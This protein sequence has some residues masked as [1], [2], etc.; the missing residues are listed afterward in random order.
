MVL[1]NMFSSFGWTVWLLALI[2][3]LMLAVCTLMLT[4]NLADRVLALE[5]VLLLWLVYPLVKVYMSLVRLAR[6]GEVHEM[7]ILF[8]VFIPVPYVEASSSYAFANKYHRMLVGAAG[9]MT[10]YFLH[11]SPCWYG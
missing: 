1:Q 5:N 10:N 8:L 7:G 11:Q 6:G 9:I 4:R 2:S 3:A